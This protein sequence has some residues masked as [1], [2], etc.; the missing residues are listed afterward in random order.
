MQGSLTQM[1]RGC[2]VRSKVTLS[3]LGGRREVAKI[4]Y[5]LKALKEKKRCTGSI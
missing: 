5:D 4:A 3:Y 2:N 1:L